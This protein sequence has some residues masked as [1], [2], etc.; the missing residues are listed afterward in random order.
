MKKIT[1]LLL[2]S[3]V[4]STCVMAQTKEVKT[5]EKNLKNTI[6]DKKEDK[7]EA[8]TD[9]AHLKVKSALK[10]RKEVRRHRRSIHRQGENLEAHGV[11]HPIEKAK[12]EAKAE[13]ELKKAKE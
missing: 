10:K 7:H 11:K 1:F 2:S 8:G 6:V 3:I 4:F 9:L 13:K 12:H 5:D